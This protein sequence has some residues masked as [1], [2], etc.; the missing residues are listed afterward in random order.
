VLNSSSHSGEVSFRFKILLMVW[1]LEDLKVHFSIRLTLRRSVEIKHML[2]VNT[3]QQQNHMLKYLNINGI[4]EIKHMFRVNNV[5][6]QSHM[7]K[8]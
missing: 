7:L 3:V 4:I 8:Y 5:Q 1:T 6:Q 2:R